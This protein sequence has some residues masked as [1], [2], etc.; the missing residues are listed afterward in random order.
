MSPSG[1]SHLEGDSSIIGV[2]PGVYYTCGFGNLV[3][4]SGMLI[5][6]IRGL[7]VMWENVFPGW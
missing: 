6:P 1:C 7:N 5:G 3:V 2:Y 4:N